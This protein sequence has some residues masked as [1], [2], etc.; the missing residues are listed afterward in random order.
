MESSVTF[1]E[2]YAEVSRLA[3]ALRAAGIKPRRPRRRLPAQRAGRDHRDARDDEPRRDLVVVLARFRRAGRARPLRPDRAEGA[4]RRRRLLL[5]RQ[6]DRLSLPRLQE[7]AR[8]LPSLESTVVVPYTAAI[9]D[10]ARDSARRRS[11]TSSWRRYRPRRDPLR[12][13]ALRPSAL[14]PVLLG[15]DRRAQVHRARRG[16]HPAPAP[17][18]TPAPRRPQAR[19]SPVLL[20]DLRLDD[21]ELARVGA[22]L[23]RD[24]PAL[25]RLAVHRRGQRAV[26][27]RRRGAHDRVRHLREVHRRTPPSS[28]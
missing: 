18:G 21:V 9:R 4:V 12:A 23:A 20:H 8:N 24:A 27:L 11:C 16:R 6:D 26:R 28:A 10:I 3:Q 19:R 14:H 7:I 15:H 2:L 5:Q 13:P 1:A 22:G 17:E 25:R